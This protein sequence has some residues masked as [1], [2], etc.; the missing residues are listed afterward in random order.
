MFAMYANAF[1]QTPAGMLPE[2]EYPQRQEALARAK[3]LYLRG[4]DYCLKALELRHPGL[5]A[6]LE[7][8]DPAALEKT[9][10]EDVPYLYWAAASWMGAFS[11][12]PF[13][14][15][16]LLTLA[17]PLA[18]MA[19]AFQ[20]EEGYNKGAIDEFYI[21]VY[22]SLPASLGGSQEKARYHF[23]KAV[24]L[25]RRAHR[26][27]VRGPGHQPSSIPDAEREASS[28]TCWARPWPST[29]TPA[30]RTAWSTCSPS[31]RP[32]GCWNTSR[33][34]SCWRRHP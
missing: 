22:G 34:T 30:P 2:T 33:I 11:A 12:E 3:H 26:R 32:A 10:A 14:M 25:R 15:E 16:L 5:R 4:R 23:A 13:D 31:A 17:R 29:W 8:G 19:R 6:R 27:A 7:A 1:V 9:G 20:L 18:L 21:S 28:G 24:E